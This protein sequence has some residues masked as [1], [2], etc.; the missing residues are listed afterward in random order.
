V[1]EKAS[2]VYAVERNIFGLENKKGKSAANTLVYHSSLK[3]FIKDA[4]RT[5][6][7]NV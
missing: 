5:R 6:K 7:S 4:L 1:A 2:W 3:Y